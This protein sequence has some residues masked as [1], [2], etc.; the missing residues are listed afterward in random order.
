MNLKVKG[1]K[2]EWVKTDK[3]PYDS[4]ITSGKKDRYMTFD[5]LKGNFKKK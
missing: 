5:F 3:P 2:K 1:G 4:A